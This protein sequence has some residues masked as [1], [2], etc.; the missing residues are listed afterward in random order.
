MKRPLYSEGS[1]AKNIPRTLIFV[2]R[3]SGLVNLIYANIMPQIFNFATTF[4]ILVKVSP[5]GFESV[6]PVPVEGYKAIN[7]P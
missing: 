4:C 3:L 5:Y 1:F 2:F 6:D 7:N